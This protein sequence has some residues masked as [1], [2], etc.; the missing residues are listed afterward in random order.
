MKITNSA[1]NAPTSTVNLTVE[2]HIVG[3]VM[4]VHF[5]S[6]FWPFFFPHDFLQI[7]LT[8]SEC[9]KQCI[10]INV[11]GV[12]LNAYHNLSYFN[13]N[14]Q[15][16][17]IHHKYKDFSILP[18][19]VHFVTSKYKEK[20]LILIDH[21]HVAVKGFLH[22]IKNNKLNHPLHF[23]LTVKNIYFIK[24]GSV[25]LPPFIPS[26]LYSFQFLCFIKLTCLIICHSTFDFSFDIV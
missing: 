8:C 6:T 19:C 16:Y 14:A 12:F 21:S 25:S 7:F 9:L 17:T 15:Q 11:C 23:H 5:L 13:I 18:V 26:Y 1:V 4:H 20:I 3:D 2:L 24:K 10:F 22:I